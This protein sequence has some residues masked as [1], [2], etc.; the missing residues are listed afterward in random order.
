MTRRIVAS[1]Y[2]P[3]TAAQVYAY[4]YDGWHGIDFRPNVRIGLGDPHDRDTDQRPF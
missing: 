1:G 2:A 3:S 4:E